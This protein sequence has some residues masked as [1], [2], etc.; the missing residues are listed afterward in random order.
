MRAYNF[1]QSLYGYP[2]ANGGGFY[3]LCYDGENWSI[4]DSAFLGKSIF[5][6]AAVNSD[7]YTATEGGVFHTTDFGTSWSDIGSG[8]SHFTVSSLF[9]SDPYLFAVTSNGVWKRSLSGITS[10]LVHS[11]NEISPKS[12]ELNQNYP[13]PFNPATQIQYSVPHECS[14]SLKVYNLLG[15]EQAILFEGVRQS[16]KYVVTFDGRKL[17]SGVYFY[18]LQSGSV[19]IS[20]KFLLLK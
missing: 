19:S 4:L 16:G 18:R 12:F 7:I 13:N 6:F 17:A 2:L 11:L 10:V 1:N 5:G 20:K 8:I 9:I 3:H 15:Q 14:V